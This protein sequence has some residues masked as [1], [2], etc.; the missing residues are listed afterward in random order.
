MNIEAIRV[1]DKLDLKRIPDGKY[2]GAAPA[3]AGELQVEVTVQGGRLEDVK[4]V[5]HEEKQ[6]YAAML[7]TPRKIIQEQG[8]RGVDATTGATITSEAIINA[9]AKALGAALK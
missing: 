1:F 8:V 6:Y 9:T 2:R 7:E 3:Y 5:R 4:V